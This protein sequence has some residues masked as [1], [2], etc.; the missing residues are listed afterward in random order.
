MLTM[1]FQPQ[2]GTAV[3][4]ECLP[5]APKLVIADKDTS[6]NPQNLLKV[7]AAL[8]KV[9]DENRATYNLE[10]SM[11]C[12]CSYMYVRH[13]SPRESLFYLLFVDESFS[14]RTKNFWG[15]YF[16]FHC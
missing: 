11:V 1:R 5:P 10:Q 7:E 12:T 6:S 9:Q 4:L 13:F 16:N 3:Y 8:N 15:I 2:T 14:V